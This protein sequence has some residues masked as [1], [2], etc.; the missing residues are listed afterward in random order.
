MMRTTRFVPICHI[1]CILSNLNLQVS[2]RAQTDPE[3]RDAISTVLGLAQKW[4]DKTLDTAADVNQSTDIHTFVDDATEEK[5][6]HKALS[7]LRVLAERGSG[8]KSLDDLFGAVRTVAADIRSDPDTK[9]WFDSFFEHTGK[10]LKEPG[11][12]RSPEA[13]NKGEWLKIRW[14]ELKD[15][16][17]DVGHKWKK[18]VD[19]LQKELDEFEQRIKD[20][21][22]VAR[23]QA[24]HSKFATDLGT[25][26]SA[27]AGQGMQ[28]AITQSLWVYQDFVNVY[29]PRVLGY[30]KGMPIPR[31]VACHACLA[32]RLMDTQYRVQG[33]D[34]RV[35]P[36][37][38][39]H[40]H[41]RHH[42][43][44]PLHPQHHRRRHHR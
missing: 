7:G 41:P 4:I 21:P 26:V 27:G 40:Q 18:D 19:A 39:R 36:R 44:P 29:L 42:P 38:P 8:D 34:H 16:D 2:D 22:T 13:Q 30:T 14:D 31:Y 11:Y 33:R 24:A 3:Y 23:V 20:T 43:G 6:L 17:S 10:T 12:S 37:G 32:Q 9:E 25:A 15:A 5:H 1:V 28:A 35:R